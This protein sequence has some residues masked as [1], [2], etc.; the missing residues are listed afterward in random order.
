[1]KVPTNAAIAILVLFNPR[2]LNVAPKDNMKKK[3]V[4]KRLGVER[5]VQIAM[6]LSKKNNGGGTLYAMGS[7]L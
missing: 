3:G 1:V 4:E 6:N 7:K 2:M 5:A